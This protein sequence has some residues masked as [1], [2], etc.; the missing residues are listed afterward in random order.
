M[1]KCFNMNFRQGFRIEM[2][3]F[4]EELQQEYERE[5]DATIQCYTDYDN[6]SAECYND[7]LIMNGKLV[8]LEKTG[9]INEDELAA[10]LEKAS[11]IRINKLEELEK[12]GKKDGSKEE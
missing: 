3:N 8:M 2:V 10:L 1:D 4:M 12:E 5:L 9:F 6:V 7:N 11:E